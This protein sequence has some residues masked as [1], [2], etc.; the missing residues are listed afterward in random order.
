MREWGGVSELPTQ[1]T[2]MRYPT[3]LDILKGVVAEE[4]EEQIRKLPIDR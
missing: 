3:I 4:E 1:D 2:L